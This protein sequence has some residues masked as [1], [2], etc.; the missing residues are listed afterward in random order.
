MPSMGGPIERWRWIVTLR[1]PLLPFLDRT[2]GVPTMAARA[3]F[4][5]QRQALLQLLG[6]V[7]PLR[8]RRLL[9]ANLC[10]SE[11]QRIDH[12]QQW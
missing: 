7:L 9:A 3:V 5:E 2:F 6:I 4:P 8:G 12:Q 1:V 11:R 10:L